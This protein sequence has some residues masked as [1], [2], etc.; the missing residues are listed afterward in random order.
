VA[1]AVLFGLTVGAEIDVIA[2]LTARRFGM[3]S[4]GTIFGALMSAL[5]VGV[6][7]GPL[8]AGAF[9]DYFGGYN[10]FLLL[11]SVAMV[12]SALALLTINRDG[13]GAD[14]GHASH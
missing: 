6:A 2:Y 11:T 9:F 5:S 13:P 10:Q 3:K 12:L 8:T 14:F 7:L 1:A 4:Y